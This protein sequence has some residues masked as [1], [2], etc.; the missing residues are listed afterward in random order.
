MRPKAQT[1]RFVVPVV[2][3]LPRAVEPASVSGLW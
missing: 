1:R 2:R 3:E